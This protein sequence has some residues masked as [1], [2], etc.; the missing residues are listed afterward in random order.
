MKEEIPV[1][2]PVVEVNQPVS[3]S[4]PNVAIVT[5]ESFLAKV[6]GGLG[7]ITTANNAR[8]FKIAGI[9]VAVIVVICLLSAIFSGEKNPDYSLFFETEDGDLMLVNS[10]SKEAE[11]ITSLDDTNQYI[12]V[13]YANNTEKYLLYIEDSKLYLLNTKKADEP[14]K[15]AKDIYEYAFSENDKYVYYTDEETDL[16]VYDM[17]TSEKI[18]NGIDYVIGTTKTKIFYFKSDKLYV[19][20]LKASKDDKTKIE[21][22]VSW[23]QLS[24]DMSILAYKNEDGDLY[25]YKVSNG[26]ST[27]LVNDCQ[28]VWYQNEDFSEFIFQDGDEIIYF[29][30]GDTT[31]LANDVSYLYFADLDSL[32]LLYT[33]YDGDYTNAD[34]YYKKGDDEAVKVASNIDVGDAFIR[35]GNELY[36][37]SGKTDSNYEVTYKLYYAKIKGSKVGDDDKI[38]SN[39]SS[40]LNRTFK[41]GCLFFTSDDDESTLQIVANGKVEKVADDFYINGSFFENEDND[42]IYFI[43]DADEDGGKLNVYNGKKTEELS[44]DVYTFSYINDKQIY[45]LKDY[46]DTSG[47]LYRLNGSK[48]IE[49]AKDV[50]YISE[51][52][53]SY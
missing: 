18:D 45:I 46:E 11:K 51:P 28:Q 23:A 29:K 42:K 53:S 39:L 14:I 25:S 33:E 30:K 27:K 6:K 44:S 5:K 22:D 21:S 7:K 37:T 20:S 8:Y 9:V 38:A 49:I 50:A 12:D 3:P 17:K 10:N 34:L 26:K 31:E 47:T 48:M 43:T 24:E 13:K 4:Q 2:E 15:I 52:I 19:S 16:Y 35:D 1:I 40:R 36:Y 41:D 32:Q